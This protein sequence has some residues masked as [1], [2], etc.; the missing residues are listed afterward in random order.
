LITSNLGYGQKLKGKVKSY[1]DTYFTV[2]E[3]FG[4]FKTGLKLNNSLFHDQEVFFDQNGNITQVIEFKS[5][6]TIYCKFEGR[7]DYENNLIESVYERFDP[8]TIIDR[9]PFIIGSV[10][11]FWGEMCEMAYKN[12]ENGIPVEETIYDLM[13]RVLYKITIKRDENGNP[14]EYI[15]SDGSF[16]KFKYDNDGKRIEWYFRSSR[17]KTIITSYKYDVSGNL[18]EKNINDSFKV[19]FH[20]H[21]EHNTFAYKYDK[22]GNWKERIDYE[23]DIPMRMVVRTIEY[24]SK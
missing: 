21:Y 20:F 7:I 18:I 5:D 2:H 14:L 22:H 19:Y 3:T 24:D 15:Y 1:K 12:D 9:K 17:G 16:D 8:E 10:K 11:Y 6:G 13:G 23:D 4:K